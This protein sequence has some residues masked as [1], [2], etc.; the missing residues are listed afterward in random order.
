MLAR[1][2]LVALVATLLPSAALAG[3]RGE[4]I[5]VAAIPIGRPTWKPVDFHVVAA[6]IGTAESGYAEFVDTIAQFLPPPDHVLD[7]NFGVGPGAAHRGPYDDELGDSVARLHLREGARFTPG[8]F[9]RGKGVWLVWM[10]VPS[11]GVFGASP[12]FPRDRVI[13]NELF[14][15]HVAGA[16]YRNGRKFS[17]LADFEVPPLT[18]A[19]ESR[20]AGIDGHS[21]FPMFIAD[22]G[23]FG[24]PGTPLAGSYR[25]L[26]TMMD[27]AGHGWLVQ[28]HFAISP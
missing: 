25:Y 10:N 9:T 22:N 14:P 18:A 27:R 3:S 4:P 6:R 20:F 19:L 8:D 5:D 12:D 11:P 28:A 23:D 2:A 26:I 1:A 24:P 21:H 7:P 16:D 15:I 13:P 17:V